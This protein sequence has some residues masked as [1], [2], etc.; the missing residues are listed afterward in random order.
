MTSIMLR[1][2]QESAITASNTAEQHGVVK[3]VWSMATGTGKTV[4]A[5]TLAARRGGR[6]L[7]LVHRD[8]LIRQAVDAFRST[9][10]DQSIGVVKAEEDAWQAPV[11]VASVQSLG[12]KR[13]MRWQ[14][15]AFD[16]IIV[17]ESHHAV[18]PSYRRIL[19]HLH[20]ALLL[21]ITATPFRAD[22]ASLAQIFDAIVFDYGILDGIRDGHLVDIQAF[23]VQGDADLDSVHTTAGDFNA[24]ELETTINT[25]RRNRLVV[26]AYQT[27]AAGTKAMVFAAGVQ[28]AHDLAAAF[29]AQGIAAYA[30][31][32]SLSTELRRDI[33][34]QFH[35]GEIRVLCNAMLYTEGFDEPTIETVIMARPTKSLGLFSQMVGRG[36]RPAPGKS[37][38]ILLDIAD[39]TRRHKII[40]VKDLIGLRKD[41]PSGKS[42]M[43]RLSQEERLSASAEA[44]LGQIAIQSEHVADLFEDLV[45]TDRP[46]LDWR[47]VLGDLEDIESDLDTYEQHLRKASRYMSAPESISTPVQQTRLVDFG[48]P[49]DEARRLPKWAA[50]YALDRHKTITAEWATTRA[51]TWALLMGWDAAEAGQAMTNQLWQ[52]TSAT[53]KQRT[54]L[55]RLKTPEELLLTLTKGEA[56]RLIDT[57]LATSKPGMRHG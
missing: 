13:L 7:W 23:R 54:L 33:V 5:T 34:R 26:E 50:S 52:L 19:D 15:D 55:H 16:T 56:S 3:Q 42:V 57:L 14:P 10:P 11:V 47:D 28:H 12:P 30:A 43:E 6:T 21:G 32:G 46:T 39:N 4:T 8:E 40:S 36:T 45:V 38:M 25:P 24:G 9:W 17:D 18:A 1:P 49:E 29:Q 53:D 2:Y 41:P 20:P 51:K 22:K 44:W 27:H 35:T 48:W 31:D 37:R